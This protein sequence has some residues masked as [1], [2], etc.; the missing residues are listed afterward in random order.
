L[1]CG[2]EFLEAKIKHAP[3]RRIFYIGQDFRG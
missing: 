1:V 3:E 2:T